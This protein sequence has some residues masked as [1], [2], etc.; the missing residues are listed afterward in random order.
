MAARGACTIITGP[1]VGREQKKHKS[2]LAKANSSRGDCT[3]GWCVGRADEV[4]RVLLV[5]LVSHTNRQPT[6]IHQSVH[7]RSY[8]CSHSIVEVQ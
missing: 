2:C 4:L 8:I 5:A 1:V 7:M 6:P 3:E